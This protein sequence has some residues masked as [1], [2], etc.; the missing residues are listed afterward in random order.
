MSASV[1][2]EVRGLR[3]GY[4]SGD[5]LRGVDLS[6]QR[7]EVVAIIGRNGAGK[8]TLMRALMGLVAA[9]QE[10][11]FFG[12][13]DIG[14]LPSHRRARSGIGYVP[15]GRGL[16][17]KLTV[18]ENILMGQAIGADRRDIAVTAPASDHLHRFFPVVQAH[19]DRMAGLLSGG[20]Q[21]QVSLAR[22]LVAGPELLLLDEPSEGIQP[23]VVKDIAETLSAVSREQGLTVLFVEQNVEMIRRFAQRCY[24]LDKGRITEELVPSAFRDRDVLKRYLAV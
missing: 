7:G 16:F 23:S 17:P 19:P 5:V 11:L 2:L 15:Q 18:A 12:N 3:A 8:S 24:V 21:Q 10:R 1:L 20:E 22:A 14:R 6:V 9:R 13:A 4:G